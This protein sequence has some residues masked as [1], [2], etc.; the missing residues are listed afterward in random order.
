MVNI[1]L[2]PKPTLIFNSLLKCIGRTDTCCLK[3]QPLISCFM[4]VS[5]T[6]KTKIV[7]ALLSG[8]GC[9]G[10]DN[11][12][13][14]GFAVCRPTW[15]QSI[16]PE[17]DSLLVFKSWGDPQIFVV[18]CIQEQITTTEVDWIIW[19]LEYLCFLRG[20]LQNELGTKALQFQKILVKHTKDT[21]KTGKIS[22]QFSVAV[23]SVGR[24]HQW[25]GHD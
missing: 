6:S 16:I 22:W 24:K 10:W 12:V 15:C 18:L 25:S 19:W 17:S 8:G 23:L 2:L 20:K 9:C 3:D 14:C 7:I 21:G 11:A 1:V 13:Y 5:P 4:F